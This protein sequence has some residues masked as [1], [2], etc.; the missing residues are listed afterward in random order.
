MRNKTTFTA[1]D[2]LSYI[3]NCNH[4]LLLVI[5]RFDLSLG[6]GDKTVREICEENGID[7]DTFLALINF[8]SEGEHD[9]SKT[10]ESIKF[11]SIVR[12]LKNAHNYFLNYKLPA[13]RSKLLQ[14]VDLS[15]G[16]APFREIFL[17][18]FDDYYAEVKKHMDYENNVV[19]PYVIDLF[20][21]KRNPNYSIAIFEQKHDQIDAKMVELKNILLKYYPSKGSN[22]LL[23]EILFDIYA[24][25]QDLS[26]HNSVED[27]LFVPAAKALEQKNA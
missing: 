15:S 22:H 23:T 13:I 11:D 5:S 10:Y 8:L 16:H 26:S 27:L 17:K 18:F 21:G 14:V 2:K 4:S 9:P 19:F 20:N 7:S 6:F 25:E 12:Y 1:N 24:C 3:I